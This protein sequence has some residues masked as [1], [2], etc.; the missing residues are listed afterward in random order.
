MN[1]L[2]CYFEVFPTAAILRS[3][4]ECFWVQLSPVA[5]SGQR[6]LPDG[7]SDMIY[8]LPASAG[9][10]GADLPAGNAAPVIVGTMTHCSHVQSGAG[11]DYLGVRFRPGGLFAF[12][13]TPLHLLTNTQLS[14]DS[15]TPALG[16]RLRERLLTTP[17]WPQRLQVLEASLRQ[18]LRPD[19]PL[20]ASLAPVVQHILTVKGQTP[21]AQLSWQANLSRR[22]LERL[23]NQYVGISPK[24][25]SRIIRFRHV[26]TVMK[27]RSGDSL[28]G[29]A[30]D[31]GYTDHAHLTRDFK[32]FSGLTPSAYLQR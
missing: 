11:V 2:P 17:A 7:C 27:T 15:V 19:N 14:I 25:L 1:H 26:K 16:S 6:I 29:I 4:I 8:P 32:A 31:H 3:H 5:P 18:C 28:M 10:L 22:Q 21:V 24:L 30:F 20:V 23:F 9:P 12:I 13:N